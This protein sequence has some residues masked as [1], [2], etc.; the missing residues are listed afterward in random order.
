MEE[1]EEDWGS[2]LQAA[3]RFRYPELYESQA[4]PVEKRMSPELASTVAP[5]GLSQVDQM[6]RRQLTH[7]E[8]KGGRGLG[9]SASG[10]HRISRKPLCKNM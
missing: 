3:A 7:D 10:L 8:V 4:P 6:N 9:W 1:Q 2:L 5:E